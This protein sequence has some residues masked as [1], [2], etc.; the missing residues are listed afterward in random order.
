MA[1]KLE[2]CHDIMNKILK[3]KQN[4]S[5]TREAQ[6]EQSLR[7]IGTREAL[8]EPPYRAAGPLGPFAL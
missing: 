6:L 2:L 4:Y 3:I 5:G 8:L 7:P 1:Y